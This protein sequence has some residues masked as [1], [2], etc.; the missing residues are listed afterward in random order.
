MGGND[1]AIGGACTGNLVSVGWITMSVVCVVRNDMM[2]RTLDIDDDLLDRARAISRWEKTELLGLI[3][4]EVRSVLE[5]RRSRRTK[6]LP[7]VTIDGRRCTEDRRNAS[8]QRIREK[9]RRGHDAG[10]RRNG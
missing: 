3:D 9:V 6:L 5:G 2:K 10:S 8:W 7:R 1:V 4:M